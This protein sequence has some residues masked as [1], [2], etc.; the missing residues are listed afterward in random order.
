MHEQIQQL[1]P[2][3]DDL[4]DVEHVVT[5]I[6][7]YSDSTHL[8]NFG[9]TSLWPIYTYVLNLSKYFQFKPSMFTAH[10]LAYISQYVVVKCL[11]LILVSHITVY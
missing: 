6:S 9:T 3:P 7:V 10:H 8:I 2:N 5:A 11:N 4:P 1:L